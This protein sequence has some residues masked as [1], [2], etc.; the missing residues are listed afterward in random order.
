ME[1]TNMMWFICYSFV[2]LFEL[3]GLFMII[4]WIVN[5]LIIGKKPKWINKLVNLLLVDFEDYDDD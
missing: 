1:D 2:K 4:L 5:M 3:F